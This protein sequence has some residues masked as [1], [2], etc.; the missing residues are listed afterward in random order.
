MLFGKTI[1]VT[2]IASGI[3]A[4]IGQLALAMG[5]DVIGLDI[6]APTSRIGGAPKKRRPQPARQG[7]E[8]QADGERTNRTQPGKGAPG[9]RAAQNQACQIAR[10]IRRYADRNRTR[11]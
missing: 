1:V 3:G 6:N 8:G 11:E 4:R 10:R 5:A 2:G 9:E 7:F